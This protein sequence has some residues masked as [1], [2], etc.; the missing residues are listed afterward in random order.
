M[1]SNTSLASLGPAAPC[2]DRAG[3][4]RVAGV[5]PT[6]PRQYKAGVVGGMAGTPTVPQVAGEAAQTRGCRHMGQVP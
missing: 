3:W 1:E 4:A 2:L 6:W 5:S